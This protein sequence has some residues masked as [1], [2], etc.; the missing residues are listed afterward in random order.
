M[1]MPPL[2][3]DPI[4]RPRRKSREQ[5]QLQLGGETSFQ[6]EEASSSGRKD[7]RLLL[8]LFTR[9]HSSTRSRQSRFTR[10]T[11]RPS[12]TTASTTSTS[13]LGGSEKFFFETAEAVRTSH[14]C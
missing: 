5:L 13:K 9:T 8:L 4:L 6:Q 10:A 3:Q 14:L 12:I 11:G 7:K 1:R 2:T